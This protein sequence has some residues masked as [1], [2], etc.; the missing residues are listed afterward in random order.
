VRLAYVDE[1]YTARYYSVAAVVAHDISAPVLERELERIARDAWREHLP[2]AAWPL[3]LHGYPMFHLEG[4]WEP[5]KA[6]PR[7]AIAIYNQAMRA[8]GAQDVAVFLEGLDCTT[9]EDFPCPPH[10]LVLQ[11]LLERLDAFAG[12]V[13]EPILVICDEI[14]EP[15]RQLSSQHNH[16]RDLLTTYREQGT[17]GGR[18]STLPHVLDTVH[19]APSRHSRLLQAADLVAFLHRR[20]IT[21][22]ET[23]PRSVQAIQRL[24]DHLAPKIYLEP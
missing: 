8:I 18:C 14:E 21:V 12:I 4:E 1:S 24:W 6:R 20:R 10:Q 16:Y 9:G 13:G 2:A 5:L 7:A 22:T 11:R 23:D 19:F 17:P 15:S 3:E